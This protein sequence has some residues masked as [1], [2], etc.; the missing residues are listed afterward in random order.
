[1]ESQ[2][3]KKSDLKKLESKM[4]REEIE[5]EKQLKQLRKQEFEHPKTAEY[6]LR[7]IQKKFKL[8]TLEE[9]EGIEIVTKIEKNLY[10]IQAQAEMNTEEIER[11]RKEAVR[12]IL[13]TNIE[14]ESEMTSAEIL[15]IYKN[16]LGC[17]RG[18]GFLKDPM[19]FA[20]S[21]L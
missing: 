21:F 12:F 20:D 17:E 13:A 14:S 4:K 6:K 11:R 15:E 1:M 5:I 7:E 2:Q 18:F 8:F 9:V 3:R 10:R 19:F 16:Q